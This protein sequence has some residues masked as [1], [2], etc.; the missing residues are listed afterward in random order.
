MSKRFLFLSLLTSFV[1]AAGQQPSRPEVQ[2]FAE[3]T[4]G[5]RKIDGFFPLYWD[6]HTGKM[7]LEID[8]F[9]QELL[10]ITALSAGVGSNGMSA[11]RSNVEQISGACASNRRHEKNRRLR[12]RDRSL[13]RHRSYGSALSSCLR[14]GSARSSYG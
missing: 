3:R 4:A 2:T 14:H 9:D 13:H 12:H 8:R 11:R 1:P 10:Y 6:E 7:W 5:L